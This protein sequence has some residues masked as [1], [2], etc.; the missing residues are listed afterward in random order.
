MSEERD[1][2]FARV[3][4]ALAPLPVRTALPDWDPARIAPG[5][6]AA[7]SCT[8]FVER[9]REVGGVPLSS[10][11]G[12]M[13]WLAGKG[14]ACGYCDPGLWPELRGHFPP[15]MEVS[16]SLRRARI[17]D[18]AFA[19]T[20]A[21]GAIAETGTV[22]LTD[23]DTPVRLAALAPWAHV[24]VIPRSRIHRSIACALG[25]MPDDPNIVWVTGP[26]KTADIEGILIEGVHGPGIQ[27]AWVADDR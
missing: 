18:Y 19:I 15:Q 4:R 22:I 23:R 10:R 2:I 21:S 9:F 27:A 20:V 13:A 5:F 16:T 24:A 11:Q 12:L 3:R 8:L 7:D 26:S 6:A 17:D 25:A 1:E 14:W